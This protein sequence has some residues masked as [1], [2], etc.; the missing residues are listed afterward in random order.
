MAFS[1]SPAPVP[2]AAPRREHIVNHPWLLLVL[3]GCV[4]V[5][6]GWFPVVSSQVPLLPAF[7]VGS[8]VAGWA[9]VRRRRRH[10]LLGLP[11]LA[12][13]AGVLLLAPVSV[14]VRP[15]AELGVRVVPIVYGLPTEAAF[16]AARR[17][18]IAL[19]GCLISPWNRSHVVR[20]G[21]GLGSPPSRWIE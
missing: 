10:A 6:T 2:P 15:S 17:G 16:E 9:L 14:S 19:G 21:Y 7:L 5:Y 1:A 12:I 3:A 20:I 13:P 18:E 4:F 11:L 8:L